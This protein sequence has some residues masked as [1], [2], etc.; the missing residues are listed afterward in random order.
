MSGAKKHAVVFYA[1]DFLS[2]EFAR[3]GRR[4]SDYAR[5]YIVVSHRERDNVRA[6]DPDGIVFELGSWQAGPVN[7]LDA[8]AVGTGFNDDRYLRGYAATRIAS[9]VAPIEALCSAVLQQFD[10][11]FYVDEPVSGFPNLVFN[12]RFAAAGAVCLHFQT[13][14]IPGYM[15][16]S[17][18][19]AHAWIPELRMLENGTRIVHDHVERRLSGGAMPLYVLNY[20]SPAARLRDAATTAAKGVYRKLFRSSE[21]YLDNDPSAHFLHCRALLAAMRGGYASALGLSRLEGKY[22]LYPLHYEPEAVLNYFSEFTRQE[23]IAEQ[24]LDALPLGYELILKEHPSQP[25]AL[26]LAKWRT[27]TRN[28]R[29]IKVR[30]DVNA[31]SLLRY[32]VAV[33]SIGSTLA[34]EAALAGRPVGVLGAVYFASMPG[35]QALR[36]PRD[37]ACILDAPCADRGAIERWYGGFLE[38]HCF[39]G[40]IM[41][42]RTTEVDLERIFARLQGESA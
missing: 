10:V 1:R 20:G 37:L 35:I 24:L 33:V 15:F 25:G 26:N 5:V 6:T 9:L 12:G 19:P 2:I 16:F 42:G 38:K 22:V 28:R 3:M 7:T 8:V 13:S 18:D 32:D 14:W 21:Y 41:K 29:V 36:S 30:G 4:L 34:I 17:G 39:A 23:E 31:R 40:N 11:T 27:V